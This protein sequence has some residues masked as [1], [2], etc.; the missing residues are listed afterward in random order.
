MRRKVDNSDDVSLD[1]LLDTM[2]N[3]VAIL[4]IMLIV[5][6]LGV[7]EAVDRITSENQVTPETMSTQKLQTAAEKQQLAELQNQFQDVKKVTSQSAEEAELALKNVNLEIESKTKVLKDQ[8][9][10]QKEFELLMASAEKQ[11]LETEKKQKEIEALNRDLQEKL[12]NIQTLEAQLE[13][14]SSVGAIPAKIVNLPNP[15]PAPAGAKPFYVLVKSEKVYPVDLETFRQRANEQA[16]RII[17][18]AKLGRDPEKGIDAKRFVELFNK[19]KLIDPFFEVTITARGI[20]PVLIFKPRPG[21]GEDSAMLSRP[22]RSVFQRGVSSLD[23]TKWYAS[24]LVWPESFETYL[25]ARNVVSRLPGTAQGP[26]APSG[27]AAG[28]AP[29]NTRAHWEI[30]LGGKLRL[31]PPPPP[32]PQPPGGPAKKTDPKPQPVDTI[33]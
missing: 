26:N 30:G 17:R 15:R 3:V 2:T 33:D 10:K 31:G 7:S 16:A 1:S 32:K 28:W 4:V 14:R 29:Q 27:F 23:P 11:Q 22:R 9:K 6:Q 25:T 18:T 21:R 12:A 5:T 20:Y 13:K 8:Q 24:F 19:K